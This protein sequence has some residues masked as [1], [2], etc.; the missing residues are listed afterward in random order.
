MKIINQIFKFGSR[1][2]FIASSPCS[3]V[4]C[5]LLANKL[6]YI[7]TRQDS[8]IPPSIL[9]KDKRLDNRPSPEFTGVNII[10]HRERGQR[11][12]EEL[13]QG[14]TKVKVD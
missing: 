8:Q 9:L 4:V 10:F 13:H 2:T 6:E 3:C 7:R 11:E 14:I 5:P 12:E 1:Q